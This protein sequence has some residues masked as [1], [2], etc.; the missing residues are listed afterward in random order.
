MKT[1]KT[2][3]VLTLI[4]LSF[5]SLAQ[6]NPKFIYCEIIG[7]GKLYSTK[8]TIRVDFG[9]RMKLFGNNRM[10]DGQ[11]KPL[12]FNSMIDALNFMGKQGWEFAQAYTV[13]ISNENV[14]HYLMKKPFTELDEETKKE[15]LSTN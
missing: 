13:A 1:T 14:C 6:E 8:V 12:V 3:L 2:L 5:Y 15:F 7:I 9:Q 11:G 4:C 10:K